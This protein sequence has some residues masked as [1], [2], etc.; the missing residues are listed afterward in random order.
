MRSGGA[1]EVEIGEKALATVD[2]WIMRKYA[3]NKKPGNLEK[4]LARAPSETSGVL[5]RCA[6][7][8]NKWKSIR[9]GGFWADP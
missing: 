6:G 8:G 9:Y 2:S 4:A 3:K 7:S 1:Q 5:R